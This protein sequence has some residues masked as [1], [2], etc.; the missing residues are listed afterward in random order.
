MNQTID[1]LLGSWRVERTITDYLNVE[2]GTFLGTATVSL[3]DAPDGESEQAHY[4][5]SGEITLGDYSGHSSR[6]L[7]YV[8]TG[9]TSVTV[10]FRDGHSF[11]DLDLAKGA[12]VDEHLCGLDR[13]VIT[14]AAKSR[15]HMEEEWHVRGPEKDYAAVTTL[16]RIR[17]RPT[18]T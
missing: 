6:E 17:E 16:R 12:S 3:V 14:T 15:D 2:D 8:A 13:Y 1:V 4:V 18:R 11:I 9:D 10:N 5:E 7:Y